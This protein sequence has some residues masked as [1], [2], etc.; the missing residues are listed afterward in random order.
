MATIPNCVVQTIIQRDEFIFTPHD[1]GHRMDLT[2][3]NQARESD[4]NLSFAFGFQYGAIEWPRRC[5]KKRSTLAVITLKTTVGTAA[6]TP[7]SPPV[8][9]SGPVTCP[10]R[11]P[12]VSL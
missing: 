10:F 7:K 11:I 5:A 6:S 1:L 2:R 3:G 8:N 4:G 12:W 9:H